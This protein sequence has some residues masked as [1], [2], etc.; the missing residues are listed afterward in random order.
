LF[1][2]AVAT[3]LIDLGEGAG[4]SNVERELLLIADSATFAPPNSRQV[5]LGRFGADCRTT[6]K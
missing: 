5:D 6:N 1:D 2:L 4:M 3:A